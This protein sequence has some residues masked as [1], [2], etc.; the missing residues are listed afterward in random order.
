[1]HATGRTVLAIAAILIA[2]VAVNVGLAARDT[3]SIAAVD[4]VSKMSQPTLEREARKVARTGGIVCSRHGC[5]TPYMKR[6]SYELV[7]RLFD[8]NNEAWALCV[9]RR[10]S[11]GNPGAVSR[12]D[13]HNLAQFNRPSWQHAY[14]F[15]LLAWDPVYGA[16]SFFNLSGGGRSRSPWNGGTYSC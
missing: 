2:A 11:G 14:D 12:T 7:A 15:D 8:S 5:A 9:V 4:R 1:M 3:H 13:D 6:L 10:E 16:R